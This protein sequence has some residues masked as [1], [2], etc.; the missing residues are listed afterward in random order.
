MSRPDRLFETLKS[1]AEK[2]LDSGMR[3]KN[4]WDA[5]GRTCAVLVMDSTGFSRTT[6]KKGIV[7][8][9]SIIAKMRDVG[10]RIFNDHGAVGFRCEADNL[11]GEFPTAEQALS[12]AFSLHRYFKEN[13]VPLYDDETYGVCIGIGYGKLLASEHE[14]MYGDEMNLASKL[15]EDTADGGETLLTEAAYLALQNREELIAHRRFVKVS[16]VD[17]PYFDVNPV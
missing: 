14:G 15:G 5:F 2:D 16:G 17:L 3:E 8:F 12:A 13:P 11:Y 4:I 1:Y 6:Q 9:L 7:Y 10:R